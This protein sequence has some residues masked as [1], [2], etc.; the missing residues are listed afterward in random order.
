MIEA[1]GA[2]SAFQPGQ[3][4]RSRSPTEFL[5]NLRLL[6]GGVFLY[7]TRRVDDGCG[8]TRDGGDRTSIAPA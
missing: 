3:R 6:H 5:R 7:P 8:V 4:S 2:Y 1:H